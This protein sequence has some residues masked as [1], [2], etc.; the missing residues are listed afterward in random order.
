LTSKLPSIIYKYTLNNFATS[1]SNINNTANLRRC[2]C[3]PL[4][5]GGMSMEIWKVVG[6]GVSRLIRDTP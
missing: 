5:F 1:C 4:W 2:P 6:G 3:Y